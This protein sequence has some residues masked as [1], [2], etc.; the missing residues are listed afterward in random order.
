MAYFS[1]K[2]QKQFINLELNL[3]NAL[4]FT[5]SKIGLILNFKKFSCYETILMRLNEVRES[6]IILTFIIYLNLACVS[7]SGV[8]IDRQ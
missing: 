1:Q 6:T 7:D 2:E 8:I 3:F 4:A 5:N